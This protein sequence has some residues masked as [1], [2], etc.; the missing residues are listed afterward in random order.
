MVD[1]MYRQWQ[2]RNLKGGNAKVNF[3]HVHRQ[4]DEDDTDWD[5]DDIEEEDEDVDMAEAP[6]L[7]KVPKEKV[8][9]KVDNDGFTEVISRKKR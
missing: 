2:E 1:D 8:Q 6:N 9:P 7:V 3:Q 4:D 5:S